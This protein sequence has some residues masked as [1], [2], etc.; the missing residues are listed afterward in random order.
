MKK[1]ICKLMLSL[2][3]LVN[4]LYASNE[5][6]ETAEKTI[7]IKPCQVIH[8]MG[9]FDVIAQDQRHTLMEIKVKKDQH[10]RI[11][12]QEKSFIPHRT[13]DYSLALGHPVSI[14]PSIAGEPTVLDHP[15]QIHVE[16]NAKYYEKSKETAVYFNANNFK[17]FA[18]YADDQIMPFDAIQF[19]FMIPKHE[20]VVFSMNPAEALKVHYFNV[21][22]EKGNVLVNVVTEKNE[23]TDN[24]YI[25][26]PKHNFLN[27]S[28]PHNALY[29]NG[30]YGCLKSQDMI[31]SQLRS[32]KINNPDEKRIELRQKNMQDA[33]SCY[34]F[35]TW[36]KH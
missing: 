26:S 35:T 6:N 28:F 18:I 27:F 21:Y 11:V 8:F 23:Y 20:R 5:I 19:T 2:P 22:A 9:E 7:S 3:L 32:E 30:D 17:R 14:I 36:Y 25:I 10:M 29:P 1:F 15:L 16:G 31:R 33:G 4:T 13:Y 34:I 24:S 12:D